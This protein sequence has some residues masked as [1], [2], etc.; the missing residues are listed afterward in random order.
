MRAG[1]SAAGVRLA[2]LTAAV[3]VCL[4]AGAQV[5]AAEPP[6]TDPAAPTAAPTETAA[7]AAP[8]DPAAP[9]AAA[10]PADPAVPTGAGPEPVDPDAPTAEEIDAATAAA[11][12]VVRQLA[13]LADELARVQ[14]E[15]DAAHAAAAIAMDTYQSQQAEYEAAQA[16]ADSAR[17][18]L[19]E[20][21]ADLAAAH[22]E[23]VAFARAGYIQGT[24]SPGLQAMLSSDDPAQLIER[25]VLLEHAGGEKADVLVRFTVAEHVAESAADAAEQ[26][27]DRAA[28]LHQRA[29]EALAAAEEVEADTRRQVSAVEAARTE[30]L[31]ELARVQQDLTD[32]LGARDAALVYEQ[33]LAGIE[34]LSDAGE[35]G[36]PLGEVAGPGAPAAVVAAIDAA[37]RTVGT[38]YAWG[39]GTLTGPG[40]GFGVDEGVVGFDCSGLTRFAYAKAGVGIAR[41]SRAQY[42]TLPKVARGDLRPGDL[43]FWANDVTQ[44]STIHHVALYLGNGRIIEAPHSGA[45]VRVRSMYWS[46]YIGAARPSA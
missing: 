27:L 8:A 7:P 6:P 29:A 20:A 39:G 17:T 13:G 15:A 36:L 3:A 41:N 22:E 9:T 18:V 5:A 2:A 26:T 24:T 34:G 40:P 21:E 38:P 12:D 33:Q 31:A 43:V 23:L 44:P 30:V 25:A 42:A 32:L 10:V 46:G 28:V 35:V 4:V 16:A 14:A 45:Q 1:G 11:D 19:A 37:L